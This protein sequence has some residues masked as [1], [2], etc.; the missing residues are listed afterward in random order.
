[1]KTED[2]MLHTN[3]TF[4]TQYF[5]GLLEDC[6]R[7][8]TEEILRIDRALIAGYTLDAGEERA[9][10]RE[11]QTLVREFDNEV[12]R[13]GS[14][15]PQR[16]DQLGRAFQARLLPYLLLTGTAERWYSKPAGYA[17]DY[18]T[19]HQVYEN[20]AAGYGRVGPL[21]DRCFLDM[22]ATLAVQNRRGLLCREILHHYSE[23][24]ARPLTILSLACG[25][26]AEVFDVLAHPEVAGSIHFHLIDIDADALRFVDEK[27]TALGVRHN[28]TLHKANVF[29][30]AARKADGF[31]PVDCAYSLGLIDY[32]RD[33][34]VKRLL[35]FIYEILAPGGQVILGNFH[36][37]NPTRALMDYLLEW[38]L[39]HRTEED[40]SG[41]YQ[42][43]RFGQP[44]DRT[45]FENEN[46]NLFAIQRK[47]G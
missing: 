11:F 6:L 43:S 31:P 34:Y 8:F 42:E 20:R 33:S 3:D 22:P 17:G 47:N 24:P 5:F 23:A 15:E 18:L 26:A 46:V 28:L 44:A 29:R 27:A 4:A 12:R 37:Q 19:I 9:V 7:E 25:P 30:L 40:L 36:P 10:S 35:D 38:R 2:M 1:M 14:M 32:F 39:L 13:L 16:V 45:V 41:L 21:L